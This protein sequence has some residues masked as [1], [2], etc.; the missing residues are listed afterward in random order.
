MKSGNSDVKGEGN[1]GDFYLGVDSGD[2]DIRVDSGDPDVKG[3]ILG[4]LI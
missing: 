4:T 1:S 2:R 3:M